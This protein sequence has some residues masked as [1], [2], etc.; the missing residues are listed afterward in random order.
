VD[1]NKLAQINL[2]ALKNNHY[3]GR[4]I[5]LGMDESKT[6]LIQVYA[7]MGRGTDSRNRILVCDD[8]G[9]LETKA[10]DPAKMKDPRLIIYKAMD[11]IGDAFVVSNGHQTTPALI[12]RRDAGN[13]SLTGLMGLDEWQYEPDKPNY[14]PRITGLILNGPAPCAE[15]LILKKSPFGLDCQKQLYH[16]QTFQPGY[17]Y[18]VS[19][20]EGD[21]DPLPSFE[22]EPYLLP[23]SGT[24]NEIATE[25]W[26][27]L[28]K[29]NRVSLAVK[30]IDIETGKSTVIIANKYH[31]VD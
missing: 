4:I 26:G 21:G 28:N 14:T 17:G 22:G 1:I 20:Y 16:Y 11:S 8:D 31:A 5:I 24:P 6:N 2:E 23:L 25:I 13:S 15:I 19:T 12:H 18:C 7:I 10:A 29:D 27:A 9:R 30:A 3:P